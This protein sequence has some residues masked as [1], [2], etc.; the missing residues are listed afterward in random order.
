MRTFAMRAHRPRTVPQRRLVWLL[1]LALLLPVAQAAATW[2]AL[3][4]TRV[5]TGPES[6]GKQALHTGHCDLCLTAAAVSGGAL[7]GAPLSLP[8]PATRHAAPTAVVGGVSLARPVR[9]YLSRAPPF[10]SH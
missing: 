6:D 10:A 3:S 2:H 5:D 7:P 8:L 9:A 1:W 4:H